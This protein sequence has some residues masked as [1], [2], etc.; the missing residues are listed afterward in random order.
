DTIVVSIIYNGIK[1]WIPNEGN[2]ELNGKTFANLAIGSRVISSTVHPTP[3]GTFKE[4][5]TLVFSSEKDMKGKVIPRCV[6]WDF[7]A[8][9]K[10]H[11]SWSSTGCSFVKEL[12][13][14]ITCTCNHL[15]NFAILMQ[16]A[17]N[18]EVTP[19]H[20]NAL[21]VITYV[22]CA[23]SLLGEALTIVAYWT[24]MSLKEEQIKIR[25]NL[26]VAIAI[27]QITFLAGIDASETKG[28]CV[29]VA[30][31]IH[32]FYLVGFAWMLFEGVYLYLMVVKVFNTV[33]RMRLFYGVA[34]GVSL[35]IV[36]LSM[37]IAF[38]QDGGIY[39]YV[40]GDFCWVSFTNNLV[41]TF[42]TPVL[43]VC[44]VN[45]VI[46]GRVVNEIIKMQSGKTSELERIRQGA[47]ASVVLFPL[48]GLTW[49]FGVLSV[50]DAGLVFQYI[51]TILNSFQVSRPSSHLIT[52]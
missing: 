46:L 6:F 43:L 9:S 40:H 25:L 34:W 17:G 22:G 11:G 41:W 1:Q 24:L 16:V 33:V 44:L 10:V 13:K 38:N 37:L 50:T 51:F 4:N 14:E 45:A 47:K 31:L 28:L 7:K 32:Y 35:L 20:K 30:G 12:N 19:G 18:N 36:L 5:V 8:R 27:A 2:V 42:V 29:F 26:V 52:L 21:E 48:L 23:L 15:T 49:V 39:S 3:I